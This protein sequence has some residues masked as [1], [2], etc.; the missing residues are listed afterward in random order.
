K[1]V[2]NIDLC[3]TFAELA[4]TPPPATTDGRSLVS[5]LLGQPVSDWRNAGLIEHRGPALAPPAP[6][7]PDS[8]NLTEPMPNRY[9]AIRM[10]DS[11]F[12]LYANGETEYYDLKADPYELNNTAGT[13]P[14]AQT[15][16]YK[17]TISAIRNCHTAAECSAAE[18]IHL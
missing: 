10:T 17:S 7:D 16:L 5:L 14:V 12:V 2:E 13:L 1:I 8:E 18:K 3:P 11:V 6:N 4:G 9:E 15:R